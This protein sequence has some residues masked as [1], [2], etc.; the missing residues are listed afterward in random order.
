[1]S[2]SYVS[3]L[4]SISYFVPDEV[5]L[6]RKSELFCPRVPV[7]FGQGHFP[8][9]CPP[10]LGLQL[11]LLKCCFTSTDTIGILGMGAQDGHLDFHATPE[12]C[13]ALLYPSQLTGH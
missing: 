5:V 10:S 2:L 7:F 11:L 6:C 12:L 1:M 3:F 9:S 8:R 4:A 13:L